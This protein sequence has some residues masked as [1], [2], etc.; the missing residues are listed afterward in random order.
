MNEIAVECSEVDGG[1]LGRMTVSD[2][3]AGWAAADAKLDHTTTSGFG[4][5]S[6]RERL[7]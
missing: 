3:G 1:W 4:L 6:I 7:R 2:Q 5:F